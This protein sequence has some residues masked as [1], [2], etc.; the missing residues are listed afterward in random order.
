MTHPNGDERKIFCE[1]LERPMGRARTEYLDEVCGEDAGLRA[2][3]EALLNAHQEAGHFLAGARGGNAMTLDQPSM[4]EPGQAVGPYKLL[5][6]IG[7]GGMGEVWMAEQREPMQRRV[8]LKIIKAGMDTRQVVARFEAER[9]ALALMDHPNIAKVLDA[10]ATPPCEGGAWGGGRPYFVMELVKGTPI[11]RYCDDHRLS[12]RE[13][14]ELFLPVCQAIQHAHQKGI[15]HRDIKPS[16]VLIAPYDGVAV[17]KIIDFGVAKAMGQRLTERTLYTGF[18]AVVGTLEYMSPEQA[19]LNNQDIDTRSDIYALGVLLYELLTGTTPLT[20]QRLEQAAFTEVLR[21]VREEEPPKPSTRLVDSKETLPAIAEQRHTEP[22]RLPKLVRGELD[23]I[24]MK[25]MEKDRT[26]RY[27]TANGLAADVRRHLSH[28]PVDAGPP[29]AWYWLRKF[30]R[31]NRVALATVAV[32][33]LA[34]VAGTAVSTWEAIRAVKAEGLAQ[35]RLEAESAALLQVTEERNR[36]NVAHED[37]DRRATEAREVVEFLVNDLIRA[38]IPS[39]AQGNMPTVDK[40]LA[41]ADQ[42]IPQRFAEQPLIEASIRKALGEAYGELGQY[43]K[44]EEHARRAVELR[45]A[46]LGPEHADTI[47]AQN[48]LSWAVMQ[49]ARLADIDPEKLQEVSILSSRVLAIARK[50]LG[51]EDKE[52]LLAILSQA[53]ALWFQ[54]KVDETRVLCEEYLPLWK[55]VLGPEDPKTLFA[56]SA[57]SLVWQSCGDLEK[58]K[59]LGQES[60]TIQLR[61]QP[62]HPDTF[63]AMV[64]LSGVYFSLGQSDRALDMMRD[65]MYGCVRVQGLKHPFTRSVIRDYSSLARTDHFHW[66]QTRKDLEQLLDRSRRESGPEARF[67]W[68]VTATGLALLLREQGRFAEARS[69]LEKA[70]AEALR[71]HK[72]LPKR[73]DVEKVRGLALFVLGRWPGLAPRLKPAERP[74]ASFTIEA[75]FR[76]VS[77]VADGRVAPGEYGPGI[78]ARFDDDVNPGLLSAHSRSGSKAPDDLSV[79]IHTA[80]TD[81]SLFLAF[82]VRDQFVD[83]SERYA[84]E[85]WRNDFVD[86]FINGDHV[87]NDIPPGNREGFQLLADAGGHQQTAIASFTNADW[88]AATTRTA[89]GYIIELEIPLALIDTRDGPEYA[90]ATSG[91]ELLVNFG[92]GDRDAAVSAQTDYG[93]FWAEDPAFTPHDD[94]EEFW[95]VSLRLVPKP[96]GP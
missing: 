45:L 95:T 54:G 80:Y 37:A 73:P 25:A 24:V 5:E 42:L 68:C 12:L 78:E 38:A 41:E 59:Q 7:E 43:D 3:V 55:R 57:L 30:A 47:A 22:A 71:L 88:K 15:I 50:V 66:E 49:Y 87:A 35:K 26:R 19:E 46:H 10:G 72:E 53:S 60:L 18:G 29:A 23:W 84:R 79:Q 16:N 96:A 1:A 51:P 91:S 83:V 77:P 4:A 21:A 33:S 67:T 69:L 64:W 14:L 27:E 48:A 92:F 58:A 82:R 86:V 36:T 32:V 93:M 39:R 11:T 89:D 31:R 34:L 81:R 63:N 13:R 17:P 52:T 40:V 9:Q 90:P 20:H 61:V 6:R 2:R 44:A 85:P 65:A 28:E 56:M 8:A 70:L 76:A 62:N 74:P 94:G 75:P